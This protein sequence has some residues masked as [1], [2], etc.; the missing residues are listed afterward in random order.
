MI[1]LVKDLTDNEI[2]D[3]LGDNKCDYCPYSDEVEDIYGRVHTC[4]KRVTCYGGEPIFPICVDNE[5]VDKDIANE[6]RKNYGNER[7]DI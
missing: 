2:L 1:K 3:Y 5:D 6:Y 4:P 7:V